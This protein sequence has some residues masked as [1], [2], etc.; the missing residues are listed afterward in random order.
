MKIAVLKETAAGERRVSA[1]PETVKKFIALGAEV[2]VETGAGDTASLDDS[3]FAA[4]GATTGARADV[5]AGADIVLG[6]A[7][8]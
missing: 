6:V 1:T 2:A 5:L 8:P 7:G 4:V 3:A